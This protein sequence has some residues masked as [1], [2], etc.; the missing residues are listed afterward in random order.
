MMHGLRMVS[1]LSHRQGLWVRSNVGGTLRFII[2]LMDWLG[3]GHSLVGCAID[4]IMGLGMSCHHMRVLGVI[5]A[6]SLLKVALRFL[7]LVIEALK[8][9]NSV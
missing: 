5:L 7:N 1:C 3:M 8:A 4:M 9:W 2:V 6:H